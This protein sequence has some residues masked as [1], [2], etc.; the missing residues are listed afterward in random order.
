MRRICLA[1]LSVGLIAACAPRGAVVIDPAAAR[2]GQV[3]SVFIGTTRAPDP[4]TG[5][6]FGYERSEDIRYVRLDV[7]VPPQR[8]PGQID[9]PRPGRKPDLT[10]DFV[11]SEQYVMEGPT[12]FRAQLYSYDVV[13]LAKAAADALV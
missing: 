2:T 9:W 13:P 6:T 8:R 12:E 5:T 3:E 7:A 1:V 10:H 4:E 11:A